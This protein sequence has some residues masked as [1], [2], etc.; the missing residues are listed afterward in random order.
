VTPKCRTEAK[1]PVH[2]N[3]RDGETYFLPGNYAHLARHL[4]AT[5]FRNF[6]VEFSR[7][8]APQD[9]APEMGRGMWFPSFSTAPQ[10]IL[11]V[12]DGV[13]VSEIELAEM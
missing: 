10:E 1:A 3:L 9:S 2:L 8:N 11:F 4:A 5:P 7:T 13:R 12:K 6:M